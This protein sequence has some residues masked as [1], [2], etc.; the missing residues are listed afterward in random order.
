M[1]RGG[2]V[3]VASVG[4]LEAEDAVDRGRDADRA[5]TVTAVRNRRHARSHRAAAAAGRTP[6]RVVG[7]PGIAAHAPERAV[8]RPGVAELGRRGADMENRAGT[9]EALGHRVGVIGAVVLHDLGADRGD[10]ALDRVIVLAREGQPFERAQPAVGLAVARLGRLGL[11]QSTLEIAVGDEVER[12]VDRLAAGDHR[13]HQLDRRQRPRLERR[14]RVERTHVAK[15]EVGG[16]HDERS[17][18]YSLLK[19]SR[20]LR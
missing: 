13:L 5:A 10:L 4:R 2:V 20:S 11:L 19:A 8:A 9:H 18:S 12:R 14:E 6:R 3:R 15:V 16:G 7:I 17:R 1:G